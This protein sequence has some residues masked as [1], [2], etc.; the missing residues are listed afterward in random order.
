MTSNFKIIISSDLNYNDLCAEIYYLDQFVA[1]I[2]QEKGIEN[3]M[4][5][6][7]PHSINN[8]WNFRYEHFLEILNK[9]KKILGEMK[10]K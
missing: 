1:V 10:E 7:Y 5:E 9:A 6:I 3:L 4:I 2:T 8:H